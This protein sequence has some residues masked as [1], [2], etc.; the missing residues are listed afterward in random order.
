VTEAGGDPCVSRG[1]S[2][3]AN[4][5]GRTP[6][7]EAPGRSFATHSRMRTTLSRSRGKGEV[8]PPGTMVSAMVSSA[9]KARGTDRDDE[10]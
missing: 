8:A 1:E 5:F 6:I 9:P 7:T 3:G 10:V 2:R 4:R